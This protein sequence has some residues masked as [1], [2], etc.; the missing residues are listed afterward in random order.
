[1]SR[2]VVKQLIVS[3]STALERAPAQLLY[4]MCGEHLAQ[5]TQGMESQCYRY[6]HPL[7]PHGGSSAWHSHR[8]VEKSVACGDLLHLL[9]AGRLAALRQYLEHLRS[10]PLHPRL[11]ESLEMQPSRVEEEEGA[12]AFECTHH[13]AVAPGGHAECRWWCVAVC[14]THQVLLVLGEPLLSHPI[15]MHPQLDTAS[16]SALRTRHVHHAAYT[17]LARTHAT[18]LLSRTWLESRP[19]RREANTVRTGMLSSASAANDSDRSRLCCAPNGMVVDD[20]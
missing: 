9:L 3:Q 13:G 7:A 16:C 4:T 20:E 8:R 11:S 6:L 17:N 15:R 19:E 18:R 10:P 14:A 2:A 1:V 5:G 12:P